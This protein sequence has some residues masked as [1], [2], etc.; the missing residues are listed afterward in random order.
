M[1]VRK[2]T[3]AGRMYLQTQCAAG[4]I[5]RH[6]PKQRGE[7]KKVM[8]A[9]KKK[10]NAMWRK[11]ELMMLVKANF[12]AGRDLFVELGYAE[13]PDEKP[14]R[15]A[16]RNFHRRMR[17]LCAG[18]G[19]P[20][21][22]ILI[23]ETHGGDGQPVRLHHHII[24]TGTGGLLLDEIMA[25]WGM[26]GAHVRTL[27]ELSD[28]FED[29]CEYL[30][31]EDKPKHKRAYVCS[32]NMTRPEEPHRRKVS[33]HESGEV[34][35][36][37]TVVKHEFY[38]NEYGRYE[39]IFGKITDPVAFGRYWERVERDRRSAEEDRFW[40]RYATTKLRRP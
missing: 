5:P 29:T 2:E 23:T 10:I 7:R 30:L 40:R 22:Y 16:L 14:V 39:L 24:M 27:R 28:N 15:C 13:E 34:P 31:K 19:L 8:S 11:I 25:A 37:V 3:F 21:K 38:G 9:G 26:G 1:Q 36:G 18:A 35:P 6:T 33:E 32:H 17:K 20:Y 4:L 12:I